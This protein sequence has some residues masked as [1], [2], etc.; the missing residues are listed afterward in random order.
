MSFSVNERFWEE[1]FKIMFVFDLQHLG[2][3]NIVI[4]LHVG[5][6]LNSDFATFSNMLLV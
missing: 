5:F 6:F 1:F 2:A 3:I 4:H